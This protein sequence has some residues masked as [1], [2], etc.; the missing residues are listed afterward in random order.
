M[1]LIGIGSS[2]LGSVR[3]NYLIGKGL[4]AMFSYNS[5]ENGA[6]GIIGS[7]LFCG[8]NADDKISLENGGFLRLW[9]GEVG[10]IVV[11]TIFILIGFYLIISWTGTRQKFVLN[12]FNPINK[13]SIQIKR[14]FLSFS[15]KNKISARD[16]SSK[17]DK[18]VT[19]QADQEISTSSLIDNKADDLLFGD[20]SLQKCEFKNNS[21]DEKKLSK[22]SSKDTV[23]A[24]SA[25]ES[26]EKNSFISECEDDSKKSPKEESISSTKPEV[27]N[28]VMEGFKVVRAEKTEKATDLFQK[29]R[30]T[31]ISPR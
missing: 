14:T 26:P 13:L 29:G 6:G 2:L 7:W 21:P 9:F 23:K 11:A 19:P 27:L 17:K 4:S 15:F 16:E 30:G 22:S 28:D 31:T 5:H 1:V 25:Q 12:L 10:S 18:A 20:V 24:I 3:D 8:L